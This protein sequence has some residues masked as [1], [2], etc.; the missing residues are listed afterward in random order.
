MVEPNA[1]V[2][3]GERLLPRG[4]KLLARHLPQQGKYTRIQHI[5]GP[6]LLFDHVES[7]L[8]EIHLRAIRSGSN[9]RAV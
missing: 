6:D 2:C 4:D 7:C 8:L 3:E 5:P 9:G 1:E